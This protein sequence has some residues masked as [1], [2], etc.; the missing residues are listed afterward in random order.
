[1]R[2]W[3]ETVLKVVELVTVGYSFDAIKERSILPDVL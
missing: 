3:E 1:M 2:R